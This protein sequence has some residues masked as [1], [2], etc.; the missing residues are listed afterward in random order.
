MDE[1]GKDDYEY[2]GGHGEQV[3]DAAA[4]GEKAHALRAELGHGYGRYEHRSAQ[5]YAAFDVVFAHSGR[6]YGDDYKVGE[7]EVDARQPL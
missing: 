2:V 6:I 1:L 3:G 5:H 4:R 7:R